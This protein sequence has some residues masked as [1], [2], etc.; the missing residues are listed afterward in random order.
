MISGETRAGKTMV[1]LAIA[2]KLRAEGKSV[3]YLKPVGTKSFEYSTESM[4][5]DVDAAVM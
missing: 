4:D 3:S 5:V 2:S 1:A